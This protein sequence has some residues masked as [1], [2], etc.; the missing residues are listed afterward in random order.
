MPSG[1][2]WGVVRLLP[3]RKKSGIPYTSKRSLPGTPVLGSVADPAS[4]GMTALFFW[5][6]RLNVVEQ[7]DG[8]G[9]VGVIHGKAEIMFA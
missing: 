9:V 1:C 5:L 2:F 7:P 4:L 6:L 8:G 3:L